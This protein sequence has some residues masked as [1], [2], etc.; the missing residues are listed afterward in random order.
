M[1]EQSQGLMEKLAVE[2]FQVAMVHSFSFCL[3]GCAKEITWYHFAELF[4]HLYNQKH[5]LANSYWKIGILLKEIAIKCRSFR[6]H[7]QSQW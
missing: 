7:F 1:Y 3:L 6:N 5:L 4:V 2:A